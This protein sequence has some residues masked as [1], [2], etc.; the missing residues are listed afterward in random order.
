MTSN[1]QLARTILLL[2]ADLGISNEVAIA[3][4]LHQP[5]AVLVADEVVASTYAGQVALTTAAML[6]RRSGHQVFVDIPDV[7]LIGFQVP[8]AGRTLHEAIQS[9]ADKLIDGDA[10]SVG[11]PLFAPDIA[12]IFGNGTA[13]VGVRAKRIMSVGWSKWSGTLNDW[14]IQSA[15]EDCSNPF[16]VMTAAAL[17]AAELFKVTGRILLPIGNRTAGFGDVFAASKSSSFRL[18]PEETPLLNEL[19]SFDIVSAGAVSN[20]FVY[21]VA[22]IADVTGLG[23][24]F[25]KDRSDN[26]NRNRNVLLLPKDMHKPKVDTFVFSNGLT[27]EPVPRHFEEYDLASLA[28]RVVVGVDDIPTRWMLARGN[29]AW[30]G[31]GATSHFSAMASVHYA[32]SACAACLHPKDEV[33]EGDTPTVAFVSFFAGLQVA[34]D[35]MRDVSGYDLNLASRQNYWTPFHPQNE[36]PSKVYPVAGCPAGCYASQIKRAA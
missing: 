30:M 6:M 34:A 19:G 8:M 9:V 22:R 26:P 18:A 29:P 7:D 2:A 11:C 3:R 36:M 1:E 10:I 33:V 23:R 13:G 21:A 28:E 12:F 4:A 17:A 16:G 24:A 31:V 14:P 5:T 15:W 35:F 27:I 32:H 20:A 25:D